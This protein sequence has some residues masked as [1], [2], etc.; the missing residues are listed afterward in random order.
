MVEAVAAGLAGAGVGLFLPGVVERVPDG[1]P[2][3]ARRTR[4][5]GSGAGIQRGSLRSA[6]PFGVATGVL[7]G[8]VTAR[9]GLTAELP[10]FLYLA[11]LAVVLAAIDVVHH[12][13]PNALVLP[14]YPIGL[15]LLGV[16][17]AVDDDGGSYVRAIGGMAALYGAYFLLVLAHPAGLGFGDVKLAGLLGL[18]LG[19]LGWG[20]LAIGA[21]LG[22]FAG[23]IAGLVLLLARRVNRRSAIPFGPA[24]LAGAFAG[25]FWGQ[26]VAN[27]YVGGG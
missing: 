21:V 1:R 19:W 14:S 9:L 22:V 6:L 17:S 11:A 15:L 16:A 2:V 27:W 26:Q 24:M 5:D 13:L 12:R 8:A 20:V 10:A 7:F 18:H 4:W 25:I 3:L 23:G